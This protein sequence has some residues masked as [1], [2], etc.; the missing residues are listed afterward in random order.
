MRKINGKTK[1]Q[2]NSTEQG[3]ERKHFLIRLAI[4]SAVVSLLLGALPAQAPA[5]EKYIVYGPENKDPNHWQK[6]M[7]LYW[8]PMDESS[9][10]YADA[11]VLIFHSVG[12]YPY[13]MSALYVK[14]YGDIYYGKTN[15]YKIA[16]KTVFE[17]VTIQKSDTNKPKVLLSM[18][19]DRSSKYL[20]L[21]IKSRPCI[22]TVTG[23]D[24]GGTSNVVEKLEKMY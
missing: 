14:K 3:K 13:H 5:G 23:C 18:T 4:V 21:G 9:K 20:Y 16:G 12:G 17:K 11:K 1:D 8:F 15:Q 6:I 24:C 10:I 2:K 22:C 19:N 7:Y